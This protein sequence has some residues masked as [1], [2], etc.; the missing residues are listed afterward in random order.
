MTTVKF[1]KYRLKSITLDKESAKI[2]AREEMK[3]KSEKELKNLI[4]S[5]NSENFKETKKGIIFTKVFICEENIS[6]AKKIL[7]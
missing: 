3:K 2:L 7:K 6:L 5:S 4:K 1:T